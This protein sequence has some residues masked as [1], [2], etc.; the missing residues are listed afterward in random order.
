MSL[1]PLPSR[2]GLGEIAMD[3]GLTRISFDLLRT[4]ATCFC[5]ISKRDTFKMLDSPTGSHQPSSLDAGGAGLLAN[6][7][8]SHHPQPDEREILL[9]GAAWARGSVVPGSTELGSR[10]APTFVVLC[11][12]WMLL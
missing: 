11:G 7:F 1:P 12:A 10:Q 4:D 2:R 9:R 3:Q 8:I 6:S 5:L